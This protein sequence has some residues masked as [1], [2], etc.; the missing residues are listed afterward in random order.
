MNNKILFEKKNLENELVLLQNEEVSHINMNSKRSFKEN[1]FIEEIRKLKDELQKKE[2]ENNKL[3]I[4]LYKYKDKQYSNDAS[5]KNILK[6]L[7]NY[8]T[9]NRDNINYREYNKSVSVSKMN[10]K[11]NL[12]IPISKSYEEDK[13]IKSLDENNINIKI[14]K[15]NKKYLFEM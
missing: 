14:V 13:D 2:V 7:G 15:N 10:N 3:K 1:K 12:D 5:R 4:F 9:K 8:S 11:I 6:G